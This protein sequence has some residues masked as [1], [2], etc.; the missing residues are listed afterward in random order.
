MYLYLKCHRPLFENGGRRL[1]TSM[2]VVTVAG[3][4]SS[5]ICPRESQSKLA[6]FNNKEKVKWVAARQGQP[7]GD[8]V[9]AAVDIHAVYEDVQTHTTETS[10]NQRRRPQRIQTLHKRSGARE[11]FSSVYTPHGDICGLHLEDVKRETL[12]GPVIKFMMISRSNLKSLLT[13]IQSVQ[14]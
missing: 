2:S 3:G 12:E 13:M 1:R 7:R 4:D 8:R 14:V 10:A 9:A 5:V 6:H 11:R